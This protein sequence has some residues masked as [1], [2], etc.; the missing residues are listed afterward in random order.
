[1]AKASDCGSEDRGFESHHPPHEKSTRKGAFFMGWIMGME[2]SDLSAGRVKISSLDAFLLVGEFH[3]FR[4]AVRRRRGTKAIFFSGR[5]RQPSG[6]F[7]M[8]VDDG[9][10]RERPARR[11]GKKVSSGHFFSSGE[12]PVALIFHKANILQI[13]IRACRRLNYGT[14][15][16]LDFMMHAIWG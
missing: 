1:M 13:P 11:A 5:I 12:S 4:N 15:V 14:P 9:T 10:R 7:F 6:V 2:E 3:G 16:L 8:G